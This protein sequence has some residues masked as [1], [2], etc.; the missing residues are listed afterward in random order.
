METILSFPT[1]VIHLPRCKER[2]PF[3][4]EQLNRSGYTNITVY[5]AVDGLQSREVEEALKLFDYPKLDNIK[6]GAI[7]CL[8]THMKLLKHI[9]E[10]NIPISNIFEDDIHFHPHWN[11]LS[12]RYYTLTPYDY[13]VIF[14]GNQLENPTTLSEITTE[15]SYCAHAYV[16]TLEGAKKMLNTIL[17]YNLGGLCEIDC[18]IKNVRD[19]NKSLGISQPFVL[20][21]WNGT[22]YPCDFNTSSPNHCRNTGLVFQNMGFISQIDDSKIVRE[23]KRFHSKKK[24]VML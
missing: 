5:N 8:L 22:L 13:E 1:F 24:M 12:K 20:Y 2:L 4:N 17:H 9:I 16:V 6:P 7:G 23:I 19:K 11:H 3:V 15:Y 21:S 10:Q 14:I 18:I